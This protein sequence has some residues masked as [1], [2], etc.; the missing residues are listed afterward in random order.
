VPLVLITQNEAGI[1]VR[2]AILLVI[3]VVLWL[4]SRR[5]PPA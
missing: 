5:T 1:F 4:V 3:G 2:A